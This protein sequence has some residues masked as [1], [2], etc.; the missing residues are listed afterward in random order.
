MF[1]NRI[2]PAS[3]PRSLVPDNGPNPLPAPD[4]QPT[5]F[6]LALTPQRIEQLV[7]MLV[8]VG[9]SSY[10]AAREI[11]A[12]IFHYPLSIGSIHNLV[13]KAASRAAEINRQ[14]DRRL[15]CRIAAGAHDEIFQGQS[16]ALVG[17]DLDSGYC[18]LLN[19]A[20]HRD[21][22]SWSL[23]LMQLEQ[24]G[25]KPDYT[26]ADGGHAL[27]LAQRQCWPAV[28]CHGDVFHAI[29]LLQ[30][31]C[32]SADR[33]ALGAMQRAEDAQQ[34]LRRCWKKSAVVTLSGQ[35]VA[36]RQKEDRAIALADE[37]RLL[38]QW[39]AEDV[40]GLSGPDPAT[41]RELYDWIVKEIALR[42]GGQRL[43][44]KAAR[45]LAHQRD[46]LLGFAYEL[47]RQLALAADT[48]GLPL[49]L[50]KRV[51]ELE[52]ADEREG[53]YWRE[54]EKLAHQLGERLEEGRRAVAGALAATHRASSLVENLN[55]RIRPY[56][57]LRRQVG[58]EDF[59]ELLRFFFNH[60]VLGRSR[61]EGWRGQSPAAVLAGCAHD[62]W[63]QMLLGDGCPQL[64]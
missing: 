16:P 8:L 22:D 59:L 5:L 1:S 37:L 2:V 46:Q 44:G 63:L 48:A 50:I 17:V 23:H 60:H 18:Y 12:T 11:L 55:S 53:T 15:L 43:L 21:A 57:F 64:N 9:H 40:L 13:Q 28:P 34:K 51:Y 45:T 30:A 10:R 52:K 32:A 39:M 54:R 4:P 24:M 49:Y 33:R 27:R 35:Y 3:Y 56:F 14:E 38:S 19:G 61:C 29:R 62:H 25:L 26:V 20:T 31:A 42:A 7:L 41:R 6:W 36:A 58:R 47:E